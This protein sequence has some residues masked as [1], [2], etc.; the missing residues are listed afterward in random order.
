[1][2]TDI[3]GNGFKVKLLHNDAKLPHLGS[4]HSAGFDLFSIDDVTIK[5][6]C[7]AVI[8][9]GISSEIPEGFYGRIADRSGLAAKKGLTVLAGV[10][11]SD[12][13]GE[14]KVLLLNTGQIDQH[15]PI[16]TRVAQ[17]IITPHA[18]FDVFEVDEI[19]ST[20][21][22]AGGFGSTGA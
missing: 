17:V 5:A 14:W 12:Y 21:R 16:G 2:A 15:L 1:M 19:G 11:D 8:P 4:T 9:L 6:G 22:G 3:F 18:L 7:R 10:I 13:R 20:C